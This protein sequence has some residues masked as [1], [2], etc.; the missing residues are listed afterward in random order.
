GARALPRGWLEQEIV[1]YYLR[2]SSAHPDA[3]VEV[4]YTDDTRGAL[5][6]ARAAVVASG[7]ATVEAALA[8]TPFVMVYR[9]AQSS[10]LLGRW[11]VRV[12]HFAMPNLIAGRGVVPELV[13]NNFTAENIVRELRKII[14]D[15]PERA[16]MIA[17]LAE[18][19]AKLRSPSGEKRA[20]DRAAGAVVAVAQQQGPQ[21]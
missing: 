18:V 17:G 11:M 3:A 8:G 5:Q 14:P 19:R 2:F 1:A 4:S 10:W 13:Q 20:V 16:A 12:P 15:G 21:R 7:T 9:V 6:S